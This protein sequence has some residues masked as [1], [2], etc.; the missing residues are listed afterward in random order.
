MTGDRVPADEAYRI[1]LVNHV[2]TRD[3]LFPAAMA[4]AANMVSKNKLGLRFTKDA[5]N[6]ALNA[7]SL[8]DANCMESRKQAFVILSGLSEVMKALG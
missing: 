8:E 7:S 6:A 1:G 5:L 3:E 4:M 2:Y